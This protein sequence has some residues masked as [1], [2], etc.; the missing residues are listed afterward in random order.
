MFVSLIVIVKDVCVKLVPYLNNVC[1]DTSSALK[2]ILPLNCEPST[3]EIKVRLH[4]VVIT[5]SIVHAGN[6]NLAGLVLIMLLGSR[7]I[8]RK[9]ELYL[10]V[11]LS[12]IQIS[13][14]I[15]RICSKRAC[16]EYIKVERTSNVAIVSVKK[17]ILKAINKNWLINQVTNKVLLLN[18]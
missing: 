18:Y 14:I 2:T 16:T 9:L 12:S 11:I 13:N 10:K 3:A 1:L 5:T 17:T 8:I 6:S 15:K 4:S 7:N